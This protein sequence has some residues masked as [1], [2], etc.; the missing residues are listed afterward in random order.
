MNSTK[1]HPR[2]QLTLAMI[3]F[4]T[5]GLFVRQIPLPSSLIAL[6]RGLTGSVFLLIFLKVTGRN[7]SWKQIRRNRWILLLSGAAIGINWILLFESYRYTTVAAATL[8]YYMAPVFVILLSSLVLGERLTLSKLI[9]VGLTLCGMI[10]V[11]GVMRQRSGG[12]A[13][14]QGILL[15]LGAAVFYATVILLNQKLIDISAY[16]RTLVQLTVAALILLPYTLAAGP[17]TGHR[18]T[19]SET[20][21]L[22]TVGILHTGIAYVLYFGSMKLLS[23]QTVAIYSY[24]DPVVAILLSRF[25]LNEQLTEEMVVGAVL[26]LGATL[27]FELFDRRKPD[28]GNAASQNI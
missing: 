12:T 7:V 4:G 15:G 23:A 18:L 16:D 9:C 20:G 3:L 1:E 14:F 5:I 13:D 8:S 11:S 2:S 28:P 17:M 26:I 24:L 6:V 25:V 27:L 10:L 22:L 21:F 19:L